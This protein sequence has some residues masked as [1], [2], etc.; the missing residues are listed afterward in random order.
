MRQ[1]IPRFAAMAFIVAA[2]ACGG[3]GA[4][5]SPAAKPPSPTVTF[6]AKLDSPDV[7]GDFDEIQLLIEFPP[8]AWTP[9]HSHGGPGMVTVI[10]GQVV[11]RT[12]GTD[13]TYRQGEGW[14]EET[15]N[16]HQVG[17]LT[18]TTALT[19]AGFLLPKGAVLTTPRPGT[20]APPLEVIYRATWKLLSPSVSGSYAEVRNV[21]DFAPGAWTPLQKHGGPALIGV[22]EGQVTV[23]ENG[24]ERTYKAGE[25][26]IELA[27]SVY[28]AGNLSG[29]P[30]RVV[31]NYL[32]PQGAAVTTV[33]KSI[34]GGSS[35][36]FFQP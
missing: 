30:A 20:P 29:A 13:T 2:T 3:S 23:R 36:G 35:S 24:A 28:Q 14:I 1:K 9:V 11:R 18:S 8:G 34:Q 16:V 7:S 5:A 27:G 17:N 21:L 32:V 19:V 15:G 10:Q 26:W 33:N 31:S 22:V 6:Q 25:S 12:G 4:P